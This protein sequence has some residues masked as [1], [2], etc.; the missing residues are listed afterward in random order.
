[1]GITG[2]ENLSRSSEMHTRFLAEIGALQLLDVDDQCIPLEDIYKKIAQGVGGSSWESL[3]VYKH[4]KSLG[5]NKRHT[6]FL[7]LQNVLKLLFHLLKVNQRIVI[8]E[9]FSSMQINEVKPVFDV[10][11]PNSKFRKSSPGKPMFVLCVN[12]F[13]FHSGNP[14]TRKQ[15]EDLEEQCEGIPM[16][17]CYVEHGRVSFS[18]FN[19]VELPVSISLLIHMWLALEYSEQY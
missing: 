14:P 13:D 17:V 12:S 5:Y 11:P 15:I 4:L 1:M 8:T 19:K 18:S 2:L 7:G 9:L 6:V 16:K 3:E 10:Y